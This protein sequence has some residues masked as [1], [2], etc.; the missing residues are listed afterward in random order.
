MQGKRINRLNKELADL[1]SFPNFTVKV[2]DNNS[3]IW[4][5]SFKGA[6]NTLYAGE[7]FTLQF[8][9]SNEYVR[10]FFII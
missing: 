6:E 9:F 8:K 1:K 7:N 10:R 2:D 3:R 5:I 4:Y